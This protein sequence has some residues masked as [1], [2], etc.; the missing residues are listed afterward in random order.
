MTITPGVNQAVSFHERLEAEHAVIGVSN[1]L[2][3]AESRTLTLYPELQLDQAHVVLTGRGY[4]ARS[5][6]DG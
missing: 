2:N 1:C 5:M 6:R 3:A 4:N